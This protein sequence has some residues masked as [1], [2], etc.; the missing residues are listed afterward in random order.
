[1][2]GAGKGHAMVVCIM[3]SAMWYTV[4]E[5]DAGEEYLEAVTNFPVASQ[6]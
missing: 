3:M 1:M 5:N 4:C 2:R 6:G